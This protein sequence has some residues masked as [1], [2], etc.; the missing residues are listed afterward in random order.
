MWLDARKSFEPL[1]SSRVNTSPSRR[2]GRPFHK[3][4]APL[5]PLSRETSAPHKAS[6]QTR[7]GGRRGGPPGGGERADSH[8]AHGIA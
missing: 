2:S 5:A 7:P 4:M 6:D 3:G 8:S 1:E